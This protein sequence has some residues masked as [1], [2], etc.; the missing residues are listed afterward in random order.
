MSVELSRRRAL[1]LLLT[2]TAAGCGECGASGPPAPATTASVGAQ[3]DRRKADVIV[4]GAGMAGLAAAARLKEEGAQVIVLEA[5]ERVGGRVWTHRSLG[6]PLDLGASWIHGRRRNP[7]TDLADEL[8]V[9]TAPTDYGSV[10]LCDQDG[11]VVPARELRE[12]LMGWQEVKERIS[13]R[14]SQLGGDVSVGAAVTRAL[15]EEALTD[16]DERLVQWVLATEVTAAG[17]DLNRLSLTGDGTRGFA[18]GDRL[19]VGGYDQLVR[20]IGKG[21]D[22]RLDHAVRRVAHR[23]NGVTIS[24]AG[25]DFFGDRAIV[26]VPLGVLKQGGL[27]IDPGLG[28]AKLDAIRSL[29]MGTL[30]KIA[31]VFDRA[32]WPADRHFLGYA[33]KQPGYYPVFLNVARFAK[34]PALVAFVGGARARGLERKTDAVIAAEVTEVLRTMFGSK[35]VAPTDMIVTRWSSDRWSRGSYSHVPVGATSRLYDV[36]AEPVGRLRF[37]GEATSSEHA[38]TVHGA[39]ESGRR[40][41]DAILAEAG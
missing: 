22:V 24:T 39:L 5:R 7:L 15:E 9:N 31:M 14:A 34:R 8:R 27:A 13:S 40:E 35:A 28:A 18:G 32:F 29:G 33:S 23:G 38:S 37:A 30:D 10:H 16:R 21:V 6:L 19:I 20:A 41:A 11:S 12:L 36:L 25:G 1:E 26:T 17:E 2:M 3:S 4:V